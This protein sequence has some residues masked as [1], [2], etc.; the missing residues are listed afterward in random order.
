MLDVAFINIVAAGTAMLCRSPD[1]V[2]TNP[3]LASD[4]LIQPLLA[5]APEPTG[6]LINR[7]VTDLWQACQ[8]IELPAEFAEPHLAALPEFID[9]AALDV[10]Q[11]SIFFDPNLSSQPD[12]I[13]ILA[14]SI[15]SS[16][17]NESATPDLDETVLAYLLETFL[18]SLAG[19][20]DQLLAIKDD[21]QRLQS[22]HQ[23][24]AIAQ[25]QGDGER[26]RRQRAP[27]KQPPPEHRQV[28]P[29][30]AAPLGRE[31]FTHPPLAAAQHIAA[32][33][34]HIQPTPLERAPQEPQPI[35]PPP[36]YIPQPCERDAPAAPNPSPSLRPSP[37]LRPS[38]ASN[39]ALTLS[40]TQRADALGI[41]VPILDVINTTLMNRRKSADVP[42]ADLRA[43]AKEAAAIVADF[44]RLATQTPA[45]ANQLTEAT[46][47]LRAGRLSE[48]DRLLAT[49]EDHL[50][51]RS[52]EVAPHDANFALAAIEI[53][54][55]RAAMHTLVGAHNR[56]A[57]YYGFAQR[58]IPRGDDERR[59][60][61]AELEAHFYEQ[62]LL[63][64]G[65]KDGLENAARACTG[66]LSTIPDDWPSLIRA[67][68]Q[69]RLAGYLIL[70]GEKEQT[71][72]RFDIAAQL[73][74]DAAAFFERESDTA[75]YV[76]AQ[77][78]H[79]TALTRLGQFQ[80]NQGL[81]ERA[82]GLHHQTIHK[83]ATLPSS[84]QQ[85]FVKLRA[86]SALTL[87]A[88]TEFAPND[89][90]LTSALTTIRQEL[91][92]LTAP[93]TDRHKDGC[94][95]HLLAAQC[96]QSLAKWHSDNGDASAAIEHHQ[97]CKQHYTAIG[98]TDLPDSV[99]M[100][101]QIGA[102][103]SDTGVNAA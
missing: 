7:C 79:A 73:L 82:A 18:L 30:S 35:A 24:A 37:P 85:T 55:Q 40:K 59:W 25:T 92:L 49:V 68:A 101:Q 19:S 52:I 41:T 1:A 39:A 42:Q 63:Y 67:A 94:L 69:S 38:P 65:V 20:T 31:L 14:A 93:P 29:P 23:S 103:I 71:Q 13:P 61:F 6:Q 91:P 3:H 77:R 57:R 11:R 76:H 78:L 8:I 2:P 64:D 97:Q 98:F 22:E 53:R 15:V 95:L 90:L 51:R 26:A 96:H 16:A 32:P 43:A 66:A 83:A 89:E 86:S 12:V 10:S 48:C 102:R 84:T 80:R 9:Q 4:Q 54:A 33:A 100:T 74:S 99:A 56:A 36:R 34:E 45:H 28:E 75:R 60:Q 21:V 70:L 50:I 46:S 62:A 87:V 58:Y 88:L 81:I 5:S 27:P 72:D 47:L 17:F 44:E